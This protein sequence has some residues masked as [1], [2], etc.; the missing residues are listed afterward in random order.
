MIQA[1]I[2]RYLTKPWDPVDLSNTVD[3]AIERFILGQELK[4]KNVELSRAL[5]ELRSLDQAK[6]N[7]MIL[8]NH[9]LK[10]PLTSILSFASLLAESPLGEED[11]LMVSR[12]VKSAD[13]LKSLVDDVLLIVRSEMNQLKIDKT[14]VTLMNVDDCVTKDVRQLMTNKNQKLV[15]HLE[16]IA[17]EADSRLLKQV[18]LR[19]IHNAAK[20]GLEGTDIFVDTKKNS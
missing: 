5:D 10:T 3:R 7:F 8:I 4:Q 15:T 17:V 20:F 16:P 11:R 6:S 19:L 18:M 2:Y 13:R 12:I 1:H 9:E 14:A